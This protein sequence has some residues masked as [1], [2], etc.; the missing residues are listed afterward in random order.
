MQ[1]NN[2]VNKHAW[3]TLWVLFLCPKLNGTKL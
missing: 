3:Q 1:Q 2:D